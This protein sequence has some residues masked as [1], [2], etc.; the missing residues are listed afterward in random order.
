MLYLFI[1][2][3]SIFSTMTAAILS[4]CIKSRSTVG[5]PTRIQ[6]LEMPQTSG[7]SAQAIGH[8]HTSIPI[9]HGV[10][11]I[12]ATSRKPGWSNFSISRTN[13]GRSIRGL[14]PPQYFMPMRTIYE[15]SFAG[16]ASYIL[17]QKKRFNYQPGR[18]SIN[19]NR[20]H[21]FS[22]AQ[23]NLCFQPDK[24]LRQF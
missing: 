7:L 8:P 10:D 24:Y 23:F 6:R 17:S 18:D 3:R 16:V 2:N 11:V 4:S 19:G 13:P 9:S 21:C 1:C 15:I 20:R 14:Q 22:G 12:S 5:P